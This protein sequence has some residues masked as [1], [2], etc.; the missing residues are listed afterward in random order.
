MVIAPRRKL[1]N[2]TKSV[3]ATPGNGKCDGGENAPVQKW[4]FERRGISKEM[5]KK[6]AA[7]LNCPVTMFL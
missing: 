3:I 7:A 1:E 6:I 5:A 4:K 2:M